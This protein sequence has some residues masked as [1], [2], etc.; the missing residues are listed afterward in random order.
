MKT[1]AQSSAG[2]GTFTRGVH[3]PQR[4][5][6]SADVIIEVLPPPSDV[7]IP[8]LQHLGAVCEATVKPKQEV[9]LGEC[10][11]RAEAFVSAP[12]HASVAGTIGAAAMTTLPNGRHVRA[13][14]IQA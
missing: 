4:K 12:V 3:P 13:I 10:I 9:A 11:G 6:L 1:I 8:L 14:P 2:P 7:L 5:S